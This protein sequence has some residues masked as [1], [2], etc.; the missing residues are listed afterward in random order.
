MA[1]QTIAASS[2]ATRI[3][4]ATREVEAKLIGWRRDFHAN[5]ELGNRE[6]R[7]SGIVAEH[8]A[9]TR[10]RRGADRRRPQPASSAC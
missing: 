7:T 8:S 9:C 3:D 5:P 2:L 6:F 1:E 4:D 10:L